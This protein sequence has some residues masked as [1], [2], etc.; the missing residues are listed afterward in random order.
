MLSFITISHC[1]KFIQIGIHTVQ[2]CHRINFIHLITSNDITRFSLK[3]LSEQLLNNP[4]MAAKA[5]YFKIFSC[6]LVLSIKISLLYHQKYYAM[7]NNY[8]LI[9]H[10]NLYE[11]HNLYEQKVV[12]H[13]LPQNILLSSHQ[14]NFAINS[15]AMYNLQKYF[16]NLN[17]KLKSRNG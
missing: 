1:I 16:A 6:F 12:L 5:V 4:T 8:N 3:K 7:P 14:P 11:G 13:C 10:S 17:T 9:R 15:S 2:T